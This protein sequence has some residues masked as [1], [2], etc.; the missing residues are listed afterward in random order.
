RY[1][2]RNSIAVYL[3]FFLGMAGARTLLIKTAVVADIGTMSVLV[4][5]AGI[6]GA[7]ALFWAVRFTPLRILFERPQAF[8]LA[9]KPRLALQ[10]AE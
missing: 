4:T 7:L 5:L 10:P 1:C 2:G 3:A 8:W 6:V 9:S